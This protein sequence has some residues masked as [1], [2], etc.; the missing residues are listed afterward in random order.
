ME[1]A[2]YGLG[3]VEHQ[4]EK[5][6]RG[7]WE[8]A[9]VEVLEVTRLGEARIVEEFAVRYRVSG[10]V[11]VEAESPAAA[12]KQALRE[13]RRRFDG[14]RHARIEWEKEA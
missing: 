4:V 3:D 5:E 12:R 7:A 11:E 10:V 8:G 2:A 13:L 14:T 6:V 9:A 1:L